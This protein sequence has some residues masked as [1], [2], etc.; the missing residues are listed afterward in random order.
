[1]LKA[2]VAPVSSTQ[3]KSEIAKQL[4]RTVIED[5]TAIDVI[6]KQIEDNS[7]APEFG[8]ILDGNSGTDSGA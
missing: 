8:V 6:I 7:Q 3:Y 1:L 5:D 2:S 4:A